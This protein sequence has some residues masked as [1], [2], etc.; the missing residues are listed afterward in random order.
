M[1]NMN[2]SISIIILN[3]N[4]WED[5]IE[6]LES[7]YQI[8][9]P[10]YN[11]IVVDNGS[12]D[13]SIN[14]IKE[15]CEG[16]IVPNSLFFKYNPKNKPIKL[17]EY[18]KNESESIKN[19]EI[20][21]LS[22]SEKLVLI[23][24]DMNYG[25]AEGNN[26]GMKYALEA[27]NPDYILLLN[28]DTVVNKDFLGQLVELA[29]TNEKIGIVG[30]KIYYYDFEGR[31]DVVANLG[32]K[33]NLNKYPGYYDL[34]EISN[35]EDYN[36]IIECD[37]V[38]GAAMMM[39]SRQIPIK[40]LNNE[41]FFGNEDVDLCI[42]LKEQGYRV[43]SVLNSNIWHKEGI[44]R[45]KRSSALIKKVLLEIDTNLKFLK[46]HKKHYYSFLPIYIIQII[47]LYSVIIIKRFF[48]SK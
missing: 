32:G 26:I 1:N 42:K 19:K 8:N 21:R 18:S 34:T 47:K 24:N 7:L 31:N 13:E 30:P 9:Y 5:T 46:F 27:L 15:Y 23:K 28:N 17:F 38:S 16:K 33:V 29:E 22:S 45:K 41:L 44:S 37:W 36:D 40:F 43:V 11:I 12:S 6:C 3:W 10:T 35:V 25:F 20:T 2:P 4:G 48:K 14:K 39:K